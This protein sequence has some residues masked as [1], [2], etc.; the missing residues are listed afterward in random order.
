MRGVLVR[1]SVALLVACALAATAC[2]V[3]TSASQPTPAATSNVT[4]TEATCTRV[5][6]GDTIEV[7]IGGET[8]TVRYI[9]IDTPEM[10][11]DRPA[12]RTLAAE[13]TQA[14]AAL[15]EGQVVSLEK[16]VSETDQYGRL[17][18]YVFVGHLFV[19]AQLVSGGYAW[20]KSYPP[21]TKYDSLFHDLE[22]EAEDQG[23]GIWSLP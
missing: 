23:L 4:F 17:L 20:A 9:G 22:S 13:A 3:G 16:D 5:I 8:Y 21:D 2:G 18:R 1:S 19:N 14:N 12:Y 6:D 11:D 10:D 15:V 7:S